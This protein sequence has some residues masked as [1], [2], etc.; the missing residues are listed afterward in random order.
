MPIIQSARRINP[1][2]LNKNIKIGIAFPLDEI[3]FFTGTEKVR[4]QLKTNLLNLL[5]TAPGERINLPNYGIG[6]R[7]LLFQNGIN[8][9]LLAER[10]RDKVNQYITD[11]SIKKIYFKET[12]EH[13]IHMIV[14]FTYILDGTLDSIQLNFN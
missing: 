3:N 8:K 14:E 10:I 4:E 13:T 9:E 2:D 12:D 1:L 11:L 5:L 6:L 7:N